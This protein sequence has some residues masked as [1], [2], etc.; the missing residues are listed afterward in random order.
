MPLRT[1][2]NVMAQAIPQGYA[3]ATPYLIVKGAADAI[4]FY[5]RAFNAT[6]Q[7]RMPDPSGTV[8]HAEIKIGDS[9]IMLADEHPAMG[10]RGPRSL[11]GSASSIMLYV[12]D[13]DAMF[14]RALKA[15]AKS[16]RAVA[17]QFYGDR[18]GTLEDPFGH[19]WTISTH[20]EDV[21][22]DEMKRRA[23]AAFK[24]QGASKPS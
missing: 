24:S 4:D 14:E 18:S 20:V 13:V 17:N 1:E 2:D 16:R 5:K 15:G 6:E 22:P 7:F 23:E 8:M 19:V 10:Y 21:A 9:V 3:T 12:N 11:G